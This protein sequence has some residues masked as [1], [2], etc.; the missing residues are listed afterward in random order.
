MKTVLDASALLAYLKDEPGADIVEAALAESVISSVN[1]AEVVQKMLALGAN[2]NDM[3]Q[4]FQGVGLVIEPFTLDDG[5]MAGR[6]WSQTK[7]YGLSLGD[8]AC[9]AL[10]MRLEATVL[11]GDRAWQSLNLAVDIR[12]IRLLQ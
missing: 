2:V 4:N 1:W 6:L 7:E 8:R 10:G 5:E 11:T 12:M 9:L 3:L